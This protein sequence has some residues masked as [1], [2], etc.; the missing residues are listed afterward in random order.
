VRPL[1]SVD[2]P[3]LSEYAP[4]SAA[5]IFA[6]ALSVSVDAVGQDFRVYYTPPLP[7]G[8]EPGMV[9]VCHHGAGY[10]GLTFACLAKEVTDLSKGKCGVLTFDARRHGE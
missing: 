6:Q 3:D 1:R 8:N 7:S 10:S 5:N 4:I 9:L 2:P